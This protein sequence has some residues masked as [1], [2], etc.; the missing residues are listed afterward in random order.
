MNYMERIL[1]TSANNSFHYYF[2][3]LMLRRPPRSTLFP[4]T[5][6]FRSR[7]AHSSRRRCCR[8]VPAM[9]ALAAVV[10]GASSG[11]VMLAQ[12]S[13]D[14]L[15]LDEVARFDNVPV[16]VGG[17]LY[18]DILRLYRGVLDGLRAAGL[19]APDRR[20]DSIGVD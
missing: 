11:R 19:A 18:W 2:F 10:L 16:P 5:T 6:L 17:T 15:R 1:I 8:G 3:F 13:P 20:L 4:Y 7:P 9:T 14:T 12:V